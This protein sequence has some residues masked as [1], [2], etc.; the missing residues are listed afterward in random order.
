MLAWLIIPL[1]EATDALL[2][3][4]GSFNSVQKLRLSMIRYH[5]RHDSNE[6]KRKRYESSPELWSIA[7]FKL[8]EYDLHLRELT[9]REEVIRHQYRALKLLGS[10]SSWEEY[11]KYSK[12]LD[13][14]AKEYRE[15]ERNYYYLEASLLNGPVTRAYS[16]NRENPRWYLHKELRNDCAGKG[17]C[18]G[19]DCGCCQNR[20]IIPGRVKGVGHCT[21]E[22]GCCNRNRGF[23]LT[24]VEKK[25]IVKIGLD[26]LN[27]DRNRT[28]RRRLLEVF[29]SGV[30]STKKAAPNWRG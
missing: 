11:I 28:Y 13:K 22:C 9:Q 2:D 7:V 12:M 17:G 30:E 21:L 16:K 26:T 27:D 20:P 8:I 15:G 18:C 29:L 10:Q 6:V 24:S 3:Q 5:A 25:R 1:Y 14:I 23:E 19:R 4:C